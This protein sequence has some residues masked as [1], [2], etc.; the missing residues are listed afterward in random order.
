MPN[1]NFKGGGPA[2][3]QPQGPVQMYRSYQ[4]KQPL[5]T[6]W[7]PAT[8]REVECPEFVNGWT[9]VVDPRTDQGAAAAHYIEHDRSR[10]HLKTVLP[11]G[12]WSYW[13]E[14]GQAF[15]SSDEHE[16]YVPLERDPIAIIRDGDHRGN[17]TGR[18]ERVSLDE[19]VDRFGENQQVLKE[20]QDR[21]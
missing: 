12:R 14:P 10:T 8:C 11:D 21:G 17:D 9:T 3:I 16:H 5:A 1:L 6:H 4:L 7:T 13:F 20:A 18:V 15:F 2:G 19:W